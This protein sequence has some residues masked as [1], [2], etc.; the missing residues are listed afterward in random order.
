MQRERGVT[1]LE[2]MVTL[3]VAAIVLSLAVPSFQRTIANNAVRAT[4]SDLV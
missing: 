1:L 4:T 2:L 3:V